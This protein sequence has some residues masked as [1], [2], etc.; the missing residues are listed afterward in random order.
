[1]SVPLSF[2]G[3]RKQL[4]AAEASD[5]GNLFRAEREGNASR[6]SAH[7]PPPSDLQGASILIHLEA[8]TRRHR[9]LSN[10]TSPLLI[11]AYLAN[12]AGYLTQGTTKCAGC[13]FNQV[14]KG[15]KRNEERRKSR[16]GSRCRDESKHSVGAAF[17]EKALFLSA[18][19][20][21]QERRRREEEEEEEEERVREG[22]E[23][24]ARCRRSDLP[25]PRRHALP[26]P[27]PCIR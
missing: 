21:H 3:V 4:S 26:P 12:D 11:I 16:R 7:A 8:D 13:L 5:D 23:L 9:V 22:S 27:P 17:V 10:Y 2:L 18:E 14:K 24:L 1:M 20:S 6:G 25:R 15:W 19:G